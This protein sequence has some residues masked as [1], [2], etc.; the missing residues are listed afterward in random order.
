[1]RTVQNGAKHQLNNLEFLYVVGG[2]QPGGHV[3]GQATPNRPNI[4]NRLKVKSR[5]C[6]EAAISGHLVPVRSLL[7]VRRRPLRTIPYTA[8]RS[9]V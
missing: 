3:V 1:M 6:K 8:A 7:A 9:Y 5:S 2:A 4:K